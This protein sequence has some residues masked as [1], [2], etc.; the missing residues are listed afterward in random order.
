MIRYQVR[1]SAIN[2]QRSTPFPNMG[3]RFR[4][5]GTQHQ[6]DTQKWVTR[7]ARTLAECQKMNALHPFQKADYRADLVGACPR[8]YGT[9]PRPSYH[10]HHSGQQQDGYGLTAPCEQSARMSDKWRIV[11]VRY[12]KDCHTLVLDNSYGR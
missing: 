6:F 10:I 11:T 4:A 8:A 12:D 5:A 2:A 9:K 3:K 1:C 7:T